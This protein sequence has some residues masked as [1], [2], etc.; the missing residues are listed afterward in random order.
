MQG[1]SQSETDVFCFKR[2]GMVESQ[3]RARGVRDERVLAAMRT[4]PR[5][6][7]VPAE[8]RSQAYE[9]HPIPIAQGQTIS[10]PFI[11]AVMLEHLRIESSDKVL[12]IGTGSGYMTALLA[13]LADRVYSV[14]RHA[15]LANSARELLR[16]LNYNN[17]EVVT[18]DGTQG[19]RAHAPY[20]GIVV[21]AAA[22]EIP[23]RLF[24]QMRE[25]GRMIIPVGP[26]E[27]QVL[28]LVRKRE[29][30]KSITSLDACRFVPLL[31]GTDAENS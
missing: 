13:A 29:G 1:N 7:F 12:E 14:E 28:Q 2:I 25:G 11:V 31:A 21:S 9:D 4:I 19:L 20:D 10:Q 5:H 22:L 23:P 24:G 30:G 16:Q 17:V 8:Y 27:A 3:L 15:V 26:P 18:G 6:E